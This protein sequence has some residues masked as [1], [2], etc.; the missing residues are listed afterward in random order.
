[1]PRNRKGLAAAFAVAAVSTLIAGLVMAA[2]PQKINYQGRLTDAGTGLPLP[3]SHSAVFSIYDDPVSGSLLWTETTSVQADTNGVFAA[4]LGSVNPIDIDFDGPAYLKVVIDGETLDPRR[5][6]VS[7]PYAFN[8]M[9]AEN[10]DGL[11]A[12][13]YATADALSGI[14]TINDPSNPVDWSQL[15]NVPAGFADGSDEAGGSGD[16]HSLDAADGDPVDVVYVDNTGKVGVGT[17]I[18]EEKLH[19]SGDI[20]LDSG[21]DIAFGDDNTRVYHSSD[22]LHLTSEDD[23]YI[24]PDDDLYIGVDGGS[25]WVHF[26]ASFKRLGLGILNPARELQIYQPGSSTCYLQVTNTPSGTNSTDGLILGLNGAAVGFLYNQE[27]GLGLCLGTSNGTK[28]YIAGD[29]DVAI[30]NNNTSPD[31]K[32]EVDGNILADSLFLGEGSTVGH[33]EINSG[34]ASA[35]IVK[36]DQ[37]FTMGGRVWCYDEAGGGI[38]GMEA[39][40]NGTGGYLVVSRSSGYNGFLV[41]GNYNNTGNPHMSISGSSRS[42]VFDMSTSGDNSVQLPSDAISAPEL[43]DEPGVASA[44]RD[45]PTLTLSTSPTNIESRAI[46]NPAAGYCLVIGSCEV[47]ISHTNGTTSSAIFGVTTSSLTLPA[48]QDY[49]L[50]LSPN[51][52]TGIYYFPVTVQSIIA[53]STGSDTFYLVGE[54]F[55]GSFSVYEAQLSVI[56]FPTNYG[57]VDPPAPGGP[58]APENQ[59]GTALPLTEVE[60]EAERQESEAAN[61]A[62][63]EEEMAEMRARLEELEQIVEEQQQ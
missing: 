14:G 48:S 26:D 32:L 30:G 38:A 37:Y 23:I 57:T 6:L 13:D 25:D 27:P 31:Q 36:A 40:F 22:D 50:Y 9:N 12:G 11:P 15:K 1:M 56:Y 62:R 3:G 45:G 19:V 47:R 42:A 21:G 60:E 53:T 33:L 52:P 55:T 39:D 54:V 63:I 46:V 41:D 59:T 49:S 20:R 7:S 10:L 43:E 16:G 8:A 18:P 51:A 4:V 44:N 24:R 58:T 61:R 5:E 34:A 28:L 29:G 2:I 35:P 17:T